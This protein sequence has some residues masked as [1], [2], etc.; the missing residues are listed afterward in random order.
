M[1]V[2]DTAAK[3]RLMQEKRIFEIRKHKRINISV[4][5]ILTFIL[6]MTLIVM[7]FVELNTNCNY[8]QVIISQV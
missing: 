6:Q 8:T 3:E 4:H 5:V 2:A 7:T 1:L